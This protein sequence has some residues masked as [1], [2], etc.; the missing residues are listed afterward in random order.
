MWQ[1]HKNW[2][3][4]PILCSIIQQYNLTR[5]LAKVEGQVSHYRGWSEH[6]GGFCH[7][8][9]KKDVT[10]VYCA[11]RSHYSCERKICH[12]NTTTQHK[13]QRLLLSSSSFAYKE[14]LNTMPNNYQPW[15]HA[16]KR[17]VPSNVVPWPK[18]SS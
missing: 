8:P 12:S 14:T 10:G 4:M 3:S 15:C 18:A 7:Q 17:M 11:T 16:W 1:N 5:R 6:V 9:K 13:P 2:K